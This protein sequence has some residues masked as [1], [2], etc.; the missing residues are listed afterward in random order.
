MCDHVFP[1]QALN[2]FVIVVTSDGL[3]FYASPTIKEYL[4]FQQVRVLPFWL[5]LKRQYTY[6]HLSV[7]YLVSHVDEVL[8]SLFLHTVG[9]G[10]PE[11]V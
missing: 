2:G 11:C 9:C 4:G 8:G 6:N 3:M 7:K 1:V 10:S 5:L